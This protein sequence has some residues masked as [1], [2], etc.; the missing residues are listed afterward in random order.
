MGEGS[1]TVFFNSLKKPFDVKQN[2]QSDHK[3]YHQN[4]KWIDHHL[5]KKIELSELD[6]KNN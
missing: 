1:E 2:K 3:I 4:K 6:D 5:S